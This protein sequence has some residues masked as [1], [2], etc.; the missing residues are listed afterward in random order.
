M[1]AAIAS[2]V[3]E[4]VIAVVQLIMVRKE[5]S[6]WRVLKEGMHYYI[7]GIIMAAVLLFFGKLLSPSIMHTCTMILCGATVYFL[8]L[9]IM[10]DEFLLSNIKTII[11][12]INRGNYN[13]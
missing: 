3:A 7:A 5:I 12:K 1:G 8:I 11:R 2:V 10:R 13:G 6:F 9:L 4:T